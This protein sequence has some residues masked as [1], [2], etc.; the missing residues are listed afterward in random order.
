MS[1]PG[2]LL[3]LARAVRVIVIGL[4]LLLCA[5]QT[6]NGTRIGWSSSVRA[7][8]YSAAYATFNGTASIPINI[9]ENRVSFT[10]QV[11]VSKGA[12][13]IAVQDPQGQGIW[14]TTLHGNSS[15]GR[16]LDTPRTGSYTLQVEGQNTGG[17]FDIHWN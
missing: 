1:A 4:A 2:R 7:T 6:T 5:C 16:V 15:G 11:E 9:R 14:R 13:S 17:S 8:E 10:Y 3:D 12:L